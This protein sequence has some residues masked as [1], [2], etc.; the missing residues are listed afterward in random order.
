MSYSIKYCV[1]TA[2]AQA[3]IARW[4]PP[5][6]SPAAA[7]FARAA[8]G[9]CGDLER[10]RAKNLLWAAARLGDYG[11]APGMA[12]APEV[13]LHPS[14]IE[15]F[16]AHSP[17]LSPSARR[18]LRTNL[19]FIA[20]RV[21]PALRPGD[22]PLGRERAKPPYTPAEIAG[23]LAL[24]AAQPTTGRRMRASALICLAAGAGLTGGDLR[25]VRGTDVV[26]RSG[27]VVAVVRGGRA[28]RAV[29]VLARYHAR[30]LEAAAFAG[31]RL[32][33]GGRDPHRRNVTCPLVSSLAGGTGLPALDTSRLRSTWLADAAAL[34][35]LPAFMHA[36]G[37][38]CSQRL[39]DIIA[40]LDPGDEAAVVALPGG[41][42]R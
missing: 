26:R 35:G 8:V 38:T 11:I 39:G 16:A 27:G 20:R 5:S 6:V 15:R 34:T 21:V 28:P 25:A 41:S 18:T 23:F 17:G 37:I 19:R 42:A 30:L 14:V 36:A 31:D 12:A 13:L 10:E 33:C 1:R 7:G 22:A 24:A 9:R 3:Y 2:A 4:G 40:T 29:P 32:I